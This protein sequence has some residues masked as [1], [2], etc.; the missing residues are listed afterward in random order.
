MQQISKLSNFRFVTETVRWEFKTKC[1][2][3]TLYPIQR[4]L[5]NFQC[6]AIN[7]TFFL[8][9]FSSAHQGLVTGCVY[10][11]FSNFVV[12]AGTDCAGMSESKTF[13]NLR[14]YDSFFLNFAS[15]LVNVWSS[16][17]GCL[18]SFSSHSKVCCSS[19]CCR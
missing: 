14:S 3:Q 1:L 18:H 19:T 8:T 13:T 10:S 11:K 7:S 2:R 5:C 15:C 16:N 9:L 17:G 4:I 6:L 12:T